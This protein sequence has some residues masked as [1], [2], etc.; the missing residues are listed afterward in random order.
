MRTYTSR[1]HATWIHGHRPPLWEEVDQINEL[2]VVSCFVSA[3]GWALLRESLQRVI[4]KNLEVKIRLYLSMEGIGEVG[5]ATLIDAIS[6]FLTD[7][8]HISDGSQAALQVW[9][10]LDARRALF[11]PKGY[12][13]RAGT[14]YVTVVGS[15]NLT[16][17]AQSNNY[18][19][20]GELNDAG[21]FLAFADAIQTLGA[22][23]AAKGSRMNNRNCHRV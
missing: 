20:E 23:G 11:H 16:R 8:K 12:A 9:I 13:L 7:Y 22:S 1:L 4:D 21:S 5:S 2:L 14:R 10:V 6:E 18:E 19:M 3:A 17:A 15:A